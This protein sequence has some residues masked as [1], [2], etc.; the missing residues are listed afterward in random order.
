MRAVSC[1][2]SF[3]LN[4]SN[5]KLS[6]NIIPVERPPAVPKIGMPM[7][8]KFSCQCMPPPH[9]FDL[10]SIAAKTCWRRS[11]LRPFPSSSCCFSMWLTVVVVLISNYLT[12]GM[13]RSEIRHFFTMI[14]LGN[15]PLFHFLYWSTFT[16]PRSCSCSTKDSKTRSV[17]YVSKGTIGSKCLY[18]ALLRSRAQYSSLRFNLSRG[19]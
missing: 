7:P 3:L 15:P 4:N 9:F 11:L 10:S 6:S 18:W 1:I 13:I 2:E 17:V 16:C 19:S 5:R 12:A 14:D 8:I